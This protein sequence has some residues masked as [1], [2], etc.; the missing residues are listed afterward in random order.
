MLNRHPTLLRLALALALIGGTLVVASASAPGSTIQTSTVEAIAGDAP[1]MVPG[2]P[3]DGDS[4]DVGSNRAEP[5]CTE[6]A[7]GVTE[8]R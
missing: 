6:T 2:E 8:P 7:T 4:S 3:C 1:A 5:D